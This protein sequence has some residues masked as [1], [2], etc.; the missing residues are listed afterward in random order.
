MT[1]G[2]GWPLTT[3]GTVGASATNQGG[4]GSM[5]LF[6]NDTATATAKGTVQTVSRYLSGVGAT[7][8]ICY[9]LSGT[10]GTSSF[11]VRDC[12]QIPRVTAIGVTTHTN[13]GLKM[14]VGDSIGYWQ[15]SPSGGTKEFLAASLE[16]R[17]ARYLTSGAAT[18]APGVT[19]TSMTAISGAPLSLQ[20]S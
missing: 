4:L 3:P 19:Y 16:N 10:L 17:P 7:D 13:V 2:P 8:L 11:T 18:P 14:D 1:D 20:G 5:Q 9:V 6:V 15:Y 12:V